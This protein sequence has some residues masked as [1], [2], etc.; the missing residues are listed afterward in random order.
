MYKYVHTHSCPEPQEHSHA[1]FLN[2]LSV[3][4]AGK[5]SFGGTG[6]LLLPGASVFIHSILFPFTHSFTWNITHSHGLTFLTYILAVVELLSHVHLC[7]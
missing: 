2:R 6:V 1:L 4:S 5:F 3:K 7:P